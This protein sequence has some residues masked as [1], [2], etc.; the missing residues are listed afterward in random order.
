MA[1]TAIPDDAVCYFCLG[2]E[3]DDEGNSLVRDCSCRGNSGFAHLSCLAMYAEQKCRAADDGDM[4]SFREP[5]YKCTNCKQPFQNQ[6]AVD[7]ASAFAS[8]AKETYGHDGNYKWDKMRVISA[9]RLKI[10]A[11]NTK[12]TAQCGCRHSGG[13]EQQVIVNNLPNKERPQDE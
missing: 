13:A 8:F 6:L 7:L 9:L 2:E 3:G 11:L 10:E 1:T 5:W 4:T 12:P